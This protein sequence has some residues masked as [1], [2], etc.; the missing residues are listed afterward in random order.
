MK[1]KTLFFISHVTMA[2]FWATCI[3]RGQKCGVFQIRMVLAHF[4]FEST[5]NTK[6]IEDSRVVV[7]CILMTVSDL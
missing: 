3:G 6:L 1:N 5:Q 4:W 7:S 2:S